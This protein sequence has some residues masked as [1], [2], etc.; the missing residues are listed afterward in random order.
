METM[1]PLDL[2]TLVGH[3]GEIIIVIAIGFGFGFVLER[4]GFGDSRR[5]AAQ[6]YLHDMTVFKVMFTAIIVAMTLIFL[7]SNLQLLDFE[8]VFVN[9]T[10]MWPGVL[11]GLIFGVGFILGGY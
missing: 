10:Y 5:M 3:T 4:A 11:G 2:P 1:L 7:T 9:P 8:R 6:F